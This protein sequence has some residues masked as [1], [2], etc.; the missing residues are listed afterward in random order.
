M[1]AIKYDVSDVEAGGGGTQAEPAMYDGNI[2]SMVNRKKKSGGDAVSDLEVVVDIGKEY[3]RLWTYVKLPD[4]PNYDHKSHGWKVRELTDALGLPPKGSIDP[5]KITKEKP[6]VR[7]K[8]V[9]DT[10]QDG[11]YKGRI[12]NLFAPGDEPTPKKDAPA[13]AAEGEPEPWTEEELHGASDEEIHAEIDAFGLDAAKSGRGWKNKAIAAILDAQDNH[14][15]GGDSG[16]EANGGEDSLAGVEQDVVDE[17]SED[18][19]H[20]EEWPDEDVVWMVE[21]LSLDAKT[22]GRGWRPKAIAAINEFA[23]TTLNGGE[24]PVPDDEAAAA[25][26]EADTYDDETAWPLDD[27]KAEIKDRNEQG[28]EI[29][30]PGRVTRD[31]LIEALRGDDSSAEPF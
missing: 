1:A 18:A 11:E 19:G 31:K 30:I 10:D 20:Y 3:A 12:K 29:V 27:L 8:V 16:P 6:A 5:V 7:V 2:V 21:G 25:E 23:G 13:A 4:D 14:D 28:A 24:T 22:T 15:A 9:A 17:L 26:S